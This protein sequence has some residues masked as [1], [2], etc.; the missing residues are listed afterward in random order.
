MSTRA[1][2]ALKSQKEKYHSIL[3]ELVQEEENK[4]CA[5][6]LAKG[7]L[8]PINSQFSGLRKIWQR[9]G[10]ILAR[11]STYMAMP[12]EDL[13]HVFL[14]I[15]GITLCLFSSLEQLKEKKGR[16]SGKILTRTY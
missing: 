2:K 6:C 5:D 8:I 1:E 13:I 4:T 15:N 16:R 3:R 12:R 9:Q 7:I 14:K 10:N 11:E